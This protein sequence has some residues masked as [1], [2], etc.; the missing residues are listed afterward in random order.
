[1]ANGI[2]IAHKCQFSSVSQPLNT[3]FCPLFLL[4]L[5]FTVSAETQGSLDIHWH[6]LAN[7]RQPDQSCISQSYK[8][9]H[10]ITGMGGQIGPSISKQAPSMPVRKF[11][12]G[13]SIEIWSTNICYKRCSVIETCHWH[14]HWTNEV[15]SVLDICINI[16]ILII[17]DKCETKNGI[18][19]FTH[20]KAEMLIAAH[21]FAT[22]MLADMSEHTNVHRRPC[23]L[24]FDFFENEMQ[25]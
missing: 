15:Y 7:I 19:I 6:Q 13:K 10:L 16:P 2:G 9:G 20:H 25:T 4:I 22:I 17:M 5:C 12:W 3:E 8:K 24:H 23:S 21:H 1:M 11:P 14:C 18:S